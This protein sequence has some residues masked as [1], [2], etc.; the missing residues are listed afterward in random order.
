[1]TTSIK[2]AQT[3]VIVRDAQTIVIGGL[4][5]DRQSDTVS[6]FPFL[7]D[8]PVLGWLF[9][10]A[11][12][13][14]NKTNLIILLTPH[15]VKSEAD[16]EMVRDH[17]KEGYE[18]IIEES[19]GETAPE[20]ERYFDSQLTREPEGPVI[21]LRGSEPEV[22]EPPDWEWTPVEPPTEQ[23]GESVGQAPEN[24]AGR[25]VSTREEGSVPG[26]DSP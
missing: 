12:K 5:E 3:T 24:P 13:G 17:V 7:G 4:M 8:I 9:K 1:V 21:D 2:T 15:I 11:S 6:K 18:T 23:E 26:G 10:V 14:K 22:V 16:F 25:S 19:L 20:W